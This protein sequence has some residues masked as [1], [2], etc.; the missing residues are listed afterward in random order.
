MSIRF[1]GMDPWLEDPD[2]WPDF[3]V[4]LLSAM[5][6]ALNQVLPENYRAKHERHVWIHEPDAETRRALGKPDSFVVEQLQRQSNPETSPVK[7]AAP[8]TV[9][10][11]VT[12]E[13]GATFLQIVDRRRRQVVTVIEVLSPSNKYAGPDRESYPAK[14]NEY[15]GSRVNLVEIDLLRGGPRLPLGVEDPDNFT[16]YVLVSR[17]NEVPQAGLW[18][19]GL[20]DEFPE[21]PVPLSEQDSDVIFQLKPCMDRACEEGLY[22]DELVYE[23]QP[24]PRLSE[25]DFAWTR[26]ILANNT[27]PHP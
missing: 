6:A 20:R 8:Q 16:Y 15:L 22:N 18:T 10:L 7:L 13:E 1:P 23:E 26:E 25:E 21:F 14:R 27:D 3:H 19:F 12:R 4:T 11:P 9:T 2:V 17:P 24:T 5:R